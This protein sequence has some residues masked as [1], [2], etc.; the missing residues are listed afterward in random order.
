MRLTKREAVRECK[1]LWQE[2]EKSGE[3]KY[4]FLNSPAGERWTNEHYWGN[5]PLCDYAPHCIRCLLVTQYN[6]RCGELGFNDHGYSTPE[7]FEAIKG[8]KE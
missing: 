8:L 2:I 7:W 3:T 5:C 4:G 6:K 1:R